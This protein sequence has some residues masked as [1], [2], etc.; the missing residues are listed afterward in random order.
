MVEYTEVLTV[1]VTKKDLA[2]IR[3]QMEEAGMINLSAFARK[4]L[5]EGY[6]IHLDLSDVKEV[7]RLLRIN[8][9]NLNQVAKKANETGY[10]YVSE[11]KMLEKQQEELI[12]LMKL[13]MQRL[14]Q[15]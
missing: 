5:L 2:K 3:R 7:S 10:I 12:N 14:S 1:K 11:I 9:N 13:I 8:S 6:I 4:K 15:V